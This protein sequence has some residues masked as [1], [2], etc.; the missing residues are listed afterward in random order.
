MMRKMGKF[1]TQAIAARQKLEQLIESGG[2]ASE[3]GVGQD[4]DLTDTRTGAFTRFSG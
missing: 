3:A 2:E 1:S 4:E